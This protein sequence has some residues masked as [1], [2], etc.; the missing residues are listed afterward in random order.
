MLKNNRSNKMYSKKDKNKSNLIINNDKKKPKF[1][2]IK[3]MN[4]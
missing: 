2:L 1:N 3:N 4:S